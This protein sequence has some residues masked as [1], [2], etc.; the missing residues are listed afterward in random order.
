MSLL[1]K[2]CLGAVCDVKQIFFFLVFQN[3]FLSTYL[4]WKKSCFSGH[5][6]LFSHSSKLLHKLLKFHCYVLINKVFR[7]NLIRLLWVDLVSLNLDTLEIGNRNRSWHL[8]HKLGSTGSSCQRGLLLPYHIKDALYVKTQY[9]IMYCLAIQAQNT[10]ALFEQL[11]KMFHYNINFHHNSKFFRVRSSV[12]PGRNYRGQGGKWGHVPQAANLRGRQI[13]WE[14]NF[15]CII[16]YLK[17]LVS[18]Y[19]WGA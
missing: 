16:S 4:I 18:K 3:V 10:S 13:W 14:K 5:L 19:L 6:I 9:T 17:I 11:L 15:P 2:S 7:S 1:L 12:R 8:L